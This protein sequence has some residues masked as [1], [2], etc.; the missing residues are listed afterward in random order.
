VTSGSR[1]TLSAPSASCNSVT[2]VAV[3]AVIPFTVAGVHDSHGRVVLD[4]ITP[5]LMG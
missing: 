5:S 1:R 2:H 3:V 4:G